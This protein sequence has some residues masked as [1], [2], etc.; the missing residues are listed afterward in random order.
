MRSVKNEVTDDPVFISYE[1]THEFAVHERTLPADETFVSNLYRW[2]RKK[3]FLN[4]GW[5]KTLVQNYCKLDGLYSF[6]ST[7]T[8][9]DTDILVL[10]FFFSFSETIEVFI[11]LGYFGGSFAQKHKINGNLFRELDLMELRDHLS[12]N[13]T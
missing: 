5:Y 10:L 2:G 1:I 9:R 3:S 11:I 7:G 13:I 6:V 12:F 8:T 4:K